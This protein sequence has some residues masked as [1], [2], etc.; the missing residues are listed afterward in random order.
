MLLAAGVLLIDEMTHSS[1]NDLLERMF[2]HLSLDEVLDAATR[3]QL[4]LADHPPPMPAVLSPTD[5]ADRSPR[6]S[7][8]LAEHREQVLEQAIDDYPR[9]PKASVYTVFE[10][11]ADFHREL[12]RML[13]SGRSNESFAMEEEAE[14]ILLADEPPPLT[15]VIRRLAEAEFSRTIGLAAYVD[16]GATPYLGDSEIAGIMRDGYLR[17][18]ESLSVFYS[19]MLEPYGRRFRDGLTVVDLH[20]AIDAVFFGFAFRGRVVPE[21]MGPASERGSQLFAGTI[22]AIVLGFTEEV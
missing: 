15:E 6:F 8:W 12:A 18:T 7:S 19:Q 20:H 11:E 2:A 9:V 4:Y 1:R 16:L 10:S 5:R 13:F 3:L 22:E 17:E 14:D 21:A